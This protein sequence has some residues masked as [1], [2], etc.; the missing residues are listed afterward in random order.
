MTIS[1]RSLV[2]TAQVL[3]TAY[4]HC[5]ADKTDEF[6]AVGAA[7]AGSADKAAVFQEL[8]DNFV[9]MLVLAL[10]PHSSSLTTELEWHCIGLVVAW[11]SIFSALVRGQCS[12]SEAIAASA[13][14]VN[15][16]LQTTD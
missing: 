4:I 12:E 10:K 6:Y 13:P 1:A 3:S 16:A 11:K 9:Q 15:R 7:L 14:F 2:E 5:A 8:L